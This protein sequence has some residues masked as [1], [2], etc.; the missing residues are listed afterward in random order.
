MERVISNNKRNLSLYEFDTSVAIRYLSLTGPKVAPDWKPYI[1]FECYRNRTFNDRY[2]YKTTIDKLVILG[3]HIEDSPITRFEWNRYIDNQKICGVTLNEPETLL[4]AHHL[5]RH[6]GLEAS[7]PAVDLSHAGRSVTMVAN[8]L[9]FTI[10]AGQNYKTTK[11]SALSPVQLL[12]MPRM[13]R[14]I[15]LLVNAFMHET[16]FIWSVFSFA[17]YDTCV[18]QTKQTEKMTINNLKFLLDEKSEIFTDLDD[19][20]GLLFDAGAFP[21]TTINSIKELIRN[22]EDADLMRVCDY[23]NRRHGVQPDGMIPE[24]LYLLFLL[25]R[26][27]S[28]RGLTV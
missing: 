7:M 10:C 23:I 12:A 24:V 28:R 3:T 2:E 11:M 6:R 20:L 25:K 21:Y 1:E 8:V 9:D 22:R 13:I 5:R 15:E 16:F 4:I 14:S 26:K 19:K 18:V 17:I 27:R